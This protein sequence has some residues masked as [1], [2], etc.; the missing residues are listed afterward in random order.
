MNKLKLSIQRFAEEAN[1]GEAV[2]TTTEPV[3]ENT[4]AVEQK[5]TFIELLKDP[6]YFWPCSWP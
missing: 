2:E 5:A 3:V 1:N 6:E 4:P